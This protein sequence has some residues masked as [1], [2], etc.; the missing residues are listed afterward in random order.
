[1]FFTWLTISIVSEG[2]HIYDVHTEGGWGEG[3]GVSERVENCHVSADYIVFKQQI[4]C[5]CFADGGGEGS[6]NWSIFVDII[7]I[8]PLKAAILNL[9]RW[10]TIGDGGRWRECGITKLVNFCGFYKYMTPYSS[11]F[12]SKS[13]WSKR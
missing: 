4:Y 8:W 1:M 12:E 9:R 10:N 7:N 3:G 6:Q 13:H 11:H 5:S 2:T